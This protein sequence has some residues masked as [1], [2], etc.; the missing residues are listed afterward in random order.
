[1]NGLNWIQ[2]DIGE[3]GLPDVRAQAGFVS[4]DGRYYALKGSGSDNVKYLNELTNRGISGVWIY[5]IGPLGFKDNIEEPDQITTSSGSADDLINNYYE[6][7]CA[8]QGRR[9]C[10]SSADCIDTTPS[11]FYCKC[12]N[13]YYG[14]GCNCLKDDQ[15]IRVSGKINGQLGD[16]NIATQLQSYV[17]M[18]NGRSYTAIST[19]NSDSGF[20]LQLLHIFGGGI[21]WL[22]GKPIGTSKNGYQ[23]NIQNK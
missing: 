7:T 8:V 4:E 20:N 13:G 17:V 21:G 5:R 6:Q 9:K 23:V 15:P 12:K 16:L 10:H 18:N 19:L 2:S 14:N 1:M 3:S 11:G 22:F